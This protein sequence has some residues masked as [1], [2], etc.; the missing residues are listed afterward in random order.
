MP[1]PKK[2]ISEK[3]RKAIIRAMA[4]ARKAG[5]FAK[6]HFSTDRNIATDALREL[7]HTQ[8]I[9]SIK[10]RTIDHVL[11]FFWAGDGHVLTALLRDQ[12]LDV[13]WSGQPH[14]SILVK[15]DPV[16]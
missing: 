11:Y 16:G 8:Y 12:G 6:H 2:T 1:L 13:G 10:G 9:Y 4:A 15:L 5:Y 3:N 7:G 14:N